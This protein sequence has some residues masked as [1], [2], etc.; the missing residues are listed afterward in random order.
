MATSRVVRVAVFVVLTSL[1]AF[2]K[3]PFFPVPLTLQ[4]LFVILSGIILGP[5]LGALSQI[6]YITV[7]LSGIPVFANGG[8]ISYI[9]SPTFGYI[10]GFIPA[11]YTSGMLSKQLAFSPIINM[12]LAATIGTTLIYLSGLPYLYIVM[13]YI[14]GKNL[15]LY[16]TL[17]YGC[18]VFLPGDAAKIIA[19]ALIGSKV[20]VRVLRMYASR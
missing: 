2:L 6:I 16:H 9:L 10:I 1:G 14:I 4:T 7:G 8:G 17:L 18:L 5:K 15:T 11:A 19:S 3:I 12:I 20:T 13:K